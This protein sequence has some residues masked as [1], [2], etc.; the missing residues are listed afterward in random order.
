MTKP[1]NSTLKLLEAEA[2]HIFRETAAGLPLF[3]KGEIDAAWTVEPWVSRLEMEA[4]GRLIYEEPPENSL[5]TVLSAGVD[6]KN[7]E[8]DLVIKFTE[9]HRELTDWIR[10]NQE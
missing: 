6:F 8:A 7:R 5:T 9:A 10:Q 3:I 1:L 4:E 2:I